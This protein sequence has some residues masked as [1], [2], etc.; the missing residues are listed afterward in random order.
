MNEIIIYN[1]LDYY[2]SFWVK[3][4]GRLTFGVIGFDENGT[5]IDFVDCSSNTVRNLFFQNLE[6]PKSEQWYLIKG[7]L[8]NSGQTQM[9]LEDGKMESGWG[10]NLRFPANAKYI[11]PYIVNVGNGDIYIHNLKITP[12]T[13]EKSIGPFIGA[14]NLIYIWMKNNSSQYNNQQIEDILK[15]KLLP[16]NSSLMIE[17]L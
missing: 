8:Y 1:L 6:L 16:Y 10:V 2:I 15:R 5:K 7:I 11:V 3:G 9:L 12:L 13:T 4:S 17:Y 14:K